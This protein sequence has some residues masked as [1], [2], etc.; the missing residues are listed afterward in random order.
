MA[1]SRDEANLGI[2]GATAYSYTEVDW[3][4]KAD[5]C[6]YRHIGGVTS[7]YGFTAS[8]T[9]TGE[10]WDGSWHGYNP[11]VTGTDTFHGYGDLPLFDIN[12]SFVRQAQ[13]RTVSVG[14]TTS[15]MGGSARSWIDYTVPHLPDAPTSLTATRVS[16]NKVTL[17]WT[18]PTR[19]YEAMCIERSVDGGSYSEIAVLWNTATSWDD[20]TTAS[21]HAYTYQLRAYYQYAYSDYTAATASIAMTPAAPQSLTTSA[22]TGTTVTVNLVN[23]SPVATGLKYQLS[24]TTDFTGATSTT[25]SGSPVT[26]FS[27]DMTTNKYIRVCNT[28]ATGDSAWL[29]SGEIVTVTKPNKPTVT[30]NM[31]GGTWDISKSLTLTVGYSSADGSAQQYYK[32][33]YQIKPSGG[34]W[35]NTTSSANIAKAADS[36]TSWTLDMGEAD[37]FSLSVGDSI[38]FEVSVKG[39]SATWSD[40]SAWCELTVK[41]KPTVNITSPS[42]SITA[43]PLSIT[44][45]YSDPSGT[46][47]AASY[48][49]SGNGKRYPQTD[50]LPMDVTTSGGSTTLSASI[51]ASDFIFDNG[52]SYTV[53]VT[54]RSSSSLQYTANATFQTAFTEPT[55]GDLS[56]QNDPDTGYVSLLATFDND[57]SDIQYSG[58]TNTQYD[59][60]PSYVKSLTVEGQSAKWNQLTNLK[61]YD[62][63]TVNNVSVSANGTTVTLSG[64]ANASGGRLSF[65]FISA[66]FDV[67]A[68]HKYLPI[69]E[70][71]A[72]FYWQAGSTIVINGLPEQAVQT[73]SANATVTSLGCNVVASTAYSDTNKHVALI[74]LTAIFGAGNEP[75]TV[76]AFKATDVYK[77][78][79]AAGE[80]Y[81]YDAGSLV[82]IGSVGVS[83]RNLLPKMVAGTY[84][85]NG[86]TVTVDSNGVA[87]FSGKT[88]STGNIATIPLESSVV[89]TQ[90]M[91]DGGIY[92]HLNNSEANAQL[93]PNFE[94]SGGVSVMAPT[95]NPVNRI[96]AVP[97]SAVGKTIDR[98]RFWVASGITVGGTFA[99]ALMYG[100]TAATYEPYSMT[101]ITT[102]LRSAGSIHD[103]LMA[104]DDSYT[105]RRN[106][107]AV[108]IDGVNLTAGAAS[109]Y[110][111]NHR[112]T[113][114]I[115]QAA[116]Y[117]STS[118]NALCADV[119]CS[120]YGTVDGAANATVDTIFPH[121][122]G[123][124]FTSTPNGSNCSTQTA[125]NTWFQSHPVTLYYELATP[126]T[127]TATSM[128]TIQLGTAFTV[129]TELD[130][131]FDM[132]T[133]DG[134]AEADTISVS[135]VNADGTTTPLLTD[136]ASGS[137]VVDK[138]APLN[139]PYQYAVTTT[140]AAHAIKTVYVDNIIETDR[141]FAYW[142]AKV[143][144]TTEERM[145]WAKWNPDNGGIKLSRP[146]TVRKHFAGRRDPV[147]YKGA[148]VNLT[149]SPSWMQIEKADA[150]K[151]VQL[152]ED[153][154]RGVYKSCDG[155]V[156]HADFELTLNPK[157]ISVGYY[158]G[159]VLNITRIAGDRL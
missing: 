148:A 26:S 136:G 32:Y 1:W 20:T 55:A 102:T 12:D 43:M 125:M 90:E 9:A 47:A 116:K 56:M 35:G 147:S 123:I 122:S 65:N 124:L 112:F 126:T 153:G 3:E 141:W 79:L 144:E 16:D 62:A 137:G 33:S 6:S 31:N 98:I 99:P 138:Y 7:P 73:A 158:G 143:G 146:D 117:N 48:Y 81:D 107:G 45:T 106:V 133:W 108:V 74:D 145:A 127:D 14:T 130:S 22:T 75:A 39:A 80:L 2:S 115:S 105:V 41:Q 77:A 134:A 86:A 95:L 27:V 159:M 100:S 139:T 38:R 50:T 59:C 149:E 57:G 58:N 40:Y 10:W 67:I 52:E 15:M 5:K 25:V 120:Y 34:S 83:G 70:T 24:A 88:T 68:G 64:T 84:S 135:R 54:A 119:N 97:S 60:E 23:A 17:S 46:C 142:T 155:W 85:A 13:D 157:Y 19:D 94:S 121:T 4:V 140:S 44:A 76:D 51:S 49:L 37:D 132:T 93:P 131:T 109:A 42:S 11:A 150:D 154:G 156:Y 30:S 111:N 53:Y 103:T 61:T 89:I 21:D 69:N 8:A 96:F 118:T 72:A 28:N 91:I 36:G 104:D 66:G 128:S 110:G 92:M 18:A 63:G 29:T 82:S 101:T 78:K 113:I 114:A 87:T 71:T 151:F 129:G 152:I